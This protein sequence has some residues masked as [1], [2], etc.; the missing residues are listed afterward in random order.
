MTVPSPSTARQLSTGV[1][2]VRTLAG[3]DG[4]PLTA[5]VA[6]PDGPAVAVVLLVPG[7]TGSKEDFAPLLDP[8]AARGIEAVALDLPGQSGTPGPDAPA[9]YAPDALAHD[10]VLVAGA[11]RSERPD[12]PVHVLGHSYGGLVARAAVLAAPAAF[13]SL[14]LLDSGP[15]G[16][17]GGRRALVDA[18]APVLAQGGVSAVYEATM[19]LARRDPAFVEPPPLLAEFLR[20]RFTTTS[21][22]H[23]QGVGDAIR[24][25]P[26]R[27]ADLAALATR[28]LVACGAGD[29]AWPVA[30]QQDMAARLGAAF[31]VVPDAQHSPAVENPAGLLDVLVPFWL[32]ARLEG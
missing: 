1:A 15:A 29:D 3:Q 22:V 30:V 11:V 8:L 7:Y 31:A 17:Q 13:D 5:L 19:A 32:T 4:R 14:V 27:T 2:R 24:D 26:D 9:N 12:A 28:V 23:L 6:E 25:E 16:I 18:M 20:G 21:A 10:L